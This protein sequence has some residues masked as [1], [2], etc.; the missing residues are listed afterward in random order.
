[1][2]VPPHFGAVKDAL[3]NLEVTML[4][5]SLSGDF[6]SFTGTE[7]IVLET[8]LVTSDHN[9]YEGG[10]WSLGKDISINLTTPHVAAWAG[11]FNDTLTR[12]LT[13]LTA[14]T[15]FS[16]TAGPGWVRLDLSGVKKMDLAVA[17]L[18]TRLK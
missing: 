16:I 2:R 11:Y 5:I 17:I 15:D 4:F 12:P 10:E 9:V 14:G 3:G 6:A 1:M 18:E 7:N 8:R 13:N